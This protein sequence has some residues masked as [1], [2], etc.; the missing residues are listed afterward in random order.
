MGATEIY[1][2]P[3]IADKLK[4]KMVRSQYELEYGN[5]TEYVMD[6]IAQSAASNL[7]YFPVLKDA[8]DSAEIERLKTK[9]EAAKRPEFQYPLQERRWRRRQIEKIQ[10]VILYRRLRGFSPE[11][12]DESQRRT[13]LVVTNPC[14]LFSGFIREILVS[15]QLDIPSVVMALME[16]YYGPNRFRIESFKFKFQSRFQ[17]EE[18][19]NVQEMDAVHSSFWWK[20]KRRPQ[21]DGIILVVDLTSYDEYFVDEN[22]QSV[23][24]LEHALSVWKSYRGFGSQLSPSKMVLF[25]KKDLFLEKL[26]TTPLSECPLFKDHSESDCKHR[27]RHRCACQPPPQLYDVICERF[28]RAHVSW[29]FAVDAT[30]RY[31]VLYRFREYHSR[32]MRD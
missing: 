30:N 28:Y 16:A 3:F 25:T 10:P 1:W 11:T 32:L 21:L 2:R 9:L 22:G 24:K 12:L 6:D 20:I 31:E 29:T 23:N 17:E 13:N 7:N 14:L 27:G 19:L 4:E 15:Q 18:T 26:K 5:V 8:M